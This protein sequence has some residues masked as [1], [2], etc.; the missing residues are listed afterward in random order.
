M[1]AVFFV[2]DRYEDK[3]KE[4]M[5]PEEFNRF[6]RGIALEGIK[7]EIGR[8]EDC[9]FKRFLIATFGLIEGE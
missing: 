9:E 1:E 7:D 5:G 6:A 8:M 2:M 4:L 3:L